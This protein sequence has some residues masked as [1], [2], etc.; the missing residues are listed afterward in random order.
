MKNISQATVEDV[1]SLA[2]SKIFR[3][4]VEYFAEGCVVNPSVLGNEIRA[5]VEGSSSSNYKTY[6]KLERGKLKSDCS[7]PYDWGV[8]KHVIALL[9][10]WINRREDFEDMGKKS[11]D[12]AKM[13]KADLVKIVE[14]L[15]REEPQTFSKIMELALPQKISNETGSPDFVKQALRTLEHGAGYQEMSSAM[16]QLDAWRQRMKIRLQTK[17]YDY[18]AEQLCRL[19]DACAVHYGSFDDSNGQL[20]SFV[21]ECLADIEKIWSS[22][23]EKK[24]IE[25]LALIWNRAEKDDYGF[26]DSFD[27]FLIKAC[28]TSVEQQSLKKPIIQKLTMLE[29]EGGKNSKSG[30]MQYQYERVFELALNLGYINKK[31]VYLQD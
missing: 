17:Q 11:K 26:E 21:D 8:C 12:A 7:C 23:G 15:A 2:G 1:R 3:R 10:H 25:L 9:L 22:V 30:A 5:E 20:A 27:D 13:P 6:V 4:G 18:V 19:A 31:G 24:R 16:R 14:T 28:K 29:G